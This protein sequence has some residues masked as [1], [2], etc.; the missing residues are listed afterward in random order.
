MA[1]QILVVEDEKD[2][3]EVLCDLLAEHKYKA[4]H[5][6]NAE[7]ALA[8]LSDGHFDVV[9]SDVN[10]PGLNGIQLC[11]R[12][13][14]VHPDVPVILSTGAATVAT[15]VAALRAGAWDFIIKPISSQ[16]VMVAVGRAVEH[17]QVKMELRRL[18][19]ALAATRPIEGII[20]DSPA[21]KDVVDMVLRIAPS[22]AT[23]LITGESGTGKELIA[24][25]IHREGPR[26]TEP[27]VAVNCGAVPSHLLESEL[28]G[29]VKGAFTDARRDRSGL[30]VQA[31]NG[32]I[33]LDEIG[34]MPME[35]QV[36]LL[37]V[38]QERKIRPVGGDEER[39]ISCR[40]VC[41]TNRDLESEIDAG[42]FRHDLYYRI[43]V[44][45]IDAPPLRS[46]GGDVLLLA[47]HFI[48]RIASRS[49]K[50]VTGLS[51]DAARMFLEY[52]WPGNVRELENCLE[53][54]VAMSRHNEI[55][56]N[57]LPAKIREHRTS[58]IVIEGNDPDELMTL[59]QLENRYVHRVLAAC[60]GNKTRAAKVLGID[61]RSLY[62]RL[63]ETPAIEGQS[64]G[65]NGASGA[66][67]ANGASGSGNNAG[68]S[69]SGAPPVSEPTPTPAAS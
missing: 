1:L 45:T 47:M 67:G 11:E 41:A 14:Q 43:N 66:N 25:A 17:H 65:A 51:V 9:I 54:A 2:E 4:T 5:V 39:P 63:E 32:T 19:A 33:F 31:G 61:R 36:K 28:F 18:R 34:E 10:M 8:A 44:V 29:H 22:D 24:L 64:A 55:T 40:V 20:G 50:Q 16:M 56:P 48:Q 68:P 42:R 58:R 52:D 37:R 23:A 69:P 59:A 15:A 53:H 27:F 3:G 57:D 35:M 46:R 12:V 49:G 38:L 60:G 6:D 7:T 21:V 30:F 62:R 26:A 13:R